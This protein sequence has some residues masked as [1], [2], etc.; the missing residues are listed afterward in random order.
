MAVQLLNTLLSVS[1]GA[2]VFWGASVP[3]ERHSPVQQPPYDLADL[4][5]FEFLVQGSNRLAASIAW[6]NL[7]MSY[8][9]L[10]FAH[11]Q[12]SS[13]VSS[14]A[15]VLHGHCSKGKSRVADAR[16]GFS[17]YVPR[18]GC[19]LDPPGSIHKAIRF[20]V[21]PMSHSKFQALTRELL[22]MRP[23]CKPMAMAATYTSYRGRHFLPTLLAML[24]ASSQDQAAAGNWRD[25]N[26]A[27]AR[28]ESQS[29]PTRY[30][31]SKCLRSQQVKVAAVSALSQACRSV[32]RFDL[33]WPSLSSR[34]PQWDVVLRATQQTWVVQEEGRC[35]TLPLPSACPHH[36]AQPEFLSDDGSSSCSSSGG[37]EDPQLLASLSW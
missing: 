20:V 26:D 5:H 3:P 13:L 34:L 29:M 31:G 6:T 27:S 36:A 32:D 9:T 1:N 7:V 12:R 33:S 25:L 8:G 14:D 30:D 22:Q 11:V 19:T 35:S 2:T 16:P 28:H 10:R 21:A 37:S 24:G 17:W 4:A 23:L 15:N 18:H